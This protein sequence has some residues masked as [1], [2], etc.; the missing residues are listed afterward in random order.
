[1]S[2]IK[3][4]FLIDGGKIFDTK[5]E[6]YE[7]KKRVLGSNIIYY[8]KP[9]DY[10]RLYYFEPLL[11]SYPIDRVFEILNFNKKLKKQRETKHHESYLDNIAN[12]SVVYNYP[13]L[14]LMPRMFEHYKKCQNLK[15]RLHY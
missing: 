6:T 11:F 8:L 1:M 13:P 9:K 10:K 4:G 5:I 12:Y 3:Y 14:H 15:K 2:V 7:L